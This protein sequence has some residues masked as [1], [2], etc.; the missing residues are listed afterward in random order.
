MLEMR[1]LGLDFGSASCRSRYE[2]HQALTDVF[3]QVIRA[4]LYS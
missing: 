1:I 3:V 2:F 4:F